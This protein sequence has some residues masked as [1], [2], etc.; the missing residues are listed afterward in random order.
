M[1]VQRRKVLALARDDA[2]KKVVMDAFGLLLKQ[3][4]VNPSMLTLC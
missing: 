1:A 2:E 4:I 3:K